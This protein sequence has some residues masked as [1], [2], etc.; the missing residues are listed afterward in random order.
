MKNNFCLLLIWISI[1]V[2]HG[3]YGICLASND[4]SGVCIDT[5]ACTASGG[6]SDPGNLYPGESSI[7]VI[8]TF[9]LKNI[10][11]SPFLL[12]SMTVLYISKL[13]EY[14]WQE[15]NMSTGVDLFGSIRSCQSLSWWR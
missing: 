2:S 8:F 10:E 3:G 1:D 4:R 9:P 13:C 5:Q 12:L 7:Q 6:V 11:M 14:C 15:R